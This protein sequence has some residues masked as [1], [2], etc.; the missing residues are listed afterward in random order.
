M[1]H[2]PESVSEGDFQFLIGEWIMPGGGSGGFT[3]EPDLQGKILVRRNK[4]DEFKTYL[5]GT[6]RRKKQAK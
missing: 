6:A 2:Q 4:A 1:T 5:E 3:L